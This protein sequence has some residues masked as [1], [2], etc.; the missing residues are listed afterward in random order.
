M[1]LKIYSSK[2]MKSGSKNQLW[3]PVFIAL[4]YLLAFPVFDL[5]NM[6]N[7][8]GPA[9]GY[10]RVEYLYKNL[11]QAGMIWTGFIIAFAAG[12]VNA[13]NGFWYL[14]SSRKIDFYHSLPVK[15]GWLFWHRTYMG[16]LYDLIPY[17]VM[18]FLALCLGAARGYFSLELMKL[19]VGML[20]LHLIM[21]LLFYFSAVLVISMTGTLLMGGLSI[22]G[23]FL[24]GPL[25]GILVHMY[26]QAFFS[27]AYSY[28]RIESLYQGLWKYTSPLLVGISGV[29]RYFEKDFA[30]CFLTLVCV[31][32]LFGVC[33]YFAYTRRP[34]ENTGKSMV[35]RSVEP[36]LRFMITVPAG[37]GAGLVFSMMQN[38]YEVR[39]IWWIFGMILGTVLAYGM[40]GVI[41]RLD[42][43]GFFSGKL[44]FLFSVA[45]IVFCA[46][47]VRLDL[48]GYDTYIPP[49]E[50]IETVNLC[51]NNGIS[52]ENAPY[53]SCNEN[54]EYSNDR[55]GY[56][57]SEF[58]SRASNIGISAGIYQ[59]LQEIIA[60]QDIIQKESDAIW[61]MMPVQYVMKSGKSIYREYMVNNEKMD[62]LMTAVYQEGIY[63]DE[64]Y[65]FLDIDSRYL[66][67]VSGRFQ[68]S[69]YY[70][71][72]QDEREK[73]PQLA[74]ALKQDVKEATPEV[75]EEIP[76]VYLDFTYRDLPMERSE[77][78][79]RMGYS[80]KENYY[81]CVLIYPGFNRTMAMLEETG[82][83]LSIEEV[84]VDSV[85]ITYYQD[86]KL[87]ESAK[88]VVYNSQEQ[89]SQ[90]KKCMIS[91]GY[92]A[93]IMTDIVTTVDV[94]I[95]AGDKKQY[96]YLV[97]ENLPNFVTEE[98]NHLS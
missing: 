87:T 25:L 57:D 10:V 72:F 92:G 7:W 12:V 74:E 43:K 58:A 95:L 13:V 79:I 44:Q 36:V 32:L 70:S 97:K 5:L 51:L 2:I 20:V 30:G 23:I 22:M 68:D 77:E 59:G 94:V 73:L 65:A 14:Y 96:V 19:A 45:V 9:Y 85:T 39:D 38:G 69:E 54:G 42:F 6:G 35:Y 91:Q 40:T 83:P 71:L 49:C 63:Q 76:M 89:I 82:Y 86:E 8:T 16:L 84:Q 24:Y 33:A 78:E 11:W 1:K 80:K 18:E 46:A 53:I 17:V 50:D 37:L 64:K 60:V 98:L 75:Y 26:E 3:V 90:L 66:E 41:Y 93:E 48:F 61:Y 52:I 47:V 29:V 28:I 15:R 34:S 88:E 4:G 67:Y 31:M 27:T 56:M 21:Y 55:A 62:D 81:A